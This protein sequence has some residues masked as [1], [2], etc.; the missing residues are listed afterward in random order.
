MEIFLRLSTQGNHHRL[1]ASASPSVDGVLDPSGAALDPGAAPRVR[2]GC[3]GSVLW[4]GLAGG[5]TELTP[6]PDHLDTVLMSFWPSHRTLFYFLH[7]VFLTRIPHTWTEPGCY[8][9]GHQ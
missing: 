6:S 5:P 9:G 3:A 8:P 7:M 2:Q 4:Q 1:C